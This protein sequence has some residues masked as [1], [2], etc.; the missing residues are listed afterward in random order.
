MLAL[1]SRYMLACTYLAIG[2]RKTYEQLL[3]KAFEGEQSKHSFGGSFYSYLRD[4]ALA[5]NV[6]LDVDPD[7][8]QIPIMVRHISQQLNRMDYIN[9]QEAAYSFLA[10]GKF[11]RRLS[12]ENVT[13]TISVDG[14]VVGDFKGQELVLKKGIAGK[15]LNVTTNGK[16]FFF[17]EISGINAKGDVKEEDKFIKARK[18]FFNRFGQPINPSNVKQGDLIA[19]KLTLENSEKSKVENIALADILPAGFE[20]ENSRIGEVADMNWIKDQAFEDYLDVRDDRITFFTHAELKPRSFYYL[21]RAVST[22]TFKMG[23]VSAD[24][25]YNGEYHSYHG[26]QTII[27]R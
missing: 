11:T 20:I 5:L 18:S 26:A 24:A 17:A 19:V 15:T 12:K 16:L 23:P 7:N 4:E 25:M 8:V 3:P 13:A 27:V 2:E 10:L 22:G 1:D 6:L 14:K 21:V 9:T